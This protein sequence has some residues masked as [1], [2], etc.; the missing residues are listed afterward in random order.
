VT[1]TRA[2]A[3]DSSGGMLAFSGERSAFPAVAPE[4]GMGGSQSKVRR[5][6]AL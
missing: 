2:S 5:I 4:V 3:E 1:P 6:F